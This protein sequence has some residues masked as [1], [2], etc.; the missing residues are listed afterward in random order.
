MTALT[1]EDVSTRLPDILARAAAGEEFVV[2]DGG[3]PV[4]RIVPPAPEVGSVVRE[5]L[6]YRDR[7]RRTLGGMSARE[8]RDEGRRF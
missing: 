8:L 4:A 7:E 6:A 2:T 3:R 1:P 5:M